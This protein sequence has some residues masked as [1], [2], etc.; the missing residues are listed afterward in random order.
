MGRG[1]PELATRMVFFLS[2]QTAQVITT[3]WASR[4]RWLSE[5]FTSYNIF[6]GEGSAGA[7]LRR[8]PLTRAAY[9][10]A[11]APFPLTSPTTIHAKGALYSRKSYMSPPMAWA[12]VN[13]AASSAPASLGQDGGKR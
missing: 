3:N 10:A 6:A 13:L 1:N 8:I 5:R 9:S 12:G 7:M 2:S 11:G 4:R